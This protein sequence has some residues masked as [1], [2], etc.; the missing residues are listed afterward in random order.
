M[1]L[2]INKQDRLR[3][4]ITTLAIYNALFYENR[5]RQKALVSITM[6]DER[7]NSLFEIR[8]KL[9]AEI[10]KLLKRVAFQGQKIAYFSN[11]ELGMSKGSLTKQ[12][13]PHL[14][15]QFFYDDFTPINMALEYIEELYE[16]SNFD[17]DEAKELNAYFGYIVKDYYMENYDEELEQNKITLGMKKPLYTSSRKAIAN[18][19]IKFI[20]SYLNK[21]MREKWKQLENKER[22]LYILDEI[23]Q[24][25][26]IIKGIDEGYTEEY[27]LIKNYAVYI[28]LT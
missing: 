3:K 18:Y 2:K 6:G 20:Y 4:N 5:K 19:V 24:G 16:F 21:Q 23:R 17:V 22:Y 28:K 10:R 14:H 8:G 1:S 13:N 11:I 9:L 15:F 25:R 26:I 7:L 27:M 12:F